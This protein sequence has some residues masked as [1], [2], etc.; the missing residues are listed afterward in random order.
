MSYMNYSRDFNFAGRNPNEQQITPGL[1]GSSTPMTGLSEDSM[2]SPCYYGRSTMVPNAGGSSMSAIDDCSSGF[3]SASVSSFPS[4]LP[5]SASTTINEYPPQPMPLQS[6]QLPPPPPDIEPSKVIEELGEYISND[7]DPVVVANSVGLLFSY[8]VTSARS[9]EICKLMSVSPII[10]NGLYNLVT[11]PEIN[12][13]TIKSLA[14]ANLTNISKYDEGRSALL[15][16]NGQSANEWPSRGVQALLHSLQSHDSN[17]V[18]FAITAIHNLLLDRRLEVQDIAKRQIQYA[19]GI[20]YIVSQL[21]HQY[22]HKYEFKVIVL[23]CLQILAYGNKDHRLSILKSDGPRLLLRTITQNFENSPTEELIETASRVLKSLSVCP[24]N[25]DSIIRNDGIEILTRCIKR[26]NQE[27]L[28][29]CLWT[30]RNLSDVINNNL[31]DHSS[32]VNLLVERLLCILFEYSE[33]PCI[34][35][36]ALG[37]LANLTCNNDHIKEF[38]CE[39]RQLNWTGVDLLLNTIDVALR[40]GRDFRV[41][42]AEVL[43]P[44]IY[45]LCHLM[46]QPHYPKLPIER[47]RVKERF[48]MDPAFRTL[49]QWSSSSEELT[50]AVGKLHSLLI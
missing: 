8:A 40:D 6:V 39:Y 30:L 38:I 16:C 49:K 3:Q 47:Q 45:T 37:I 21:A 11:N 5:S 14:T 13:D 35:T 22:L 26:D 2:P 32:A 31:R 41:L 24:A 1:I 12:D 17:V 7:R 44:G 27:T 43:E 23:D 25:K 18:I 20:K 15:G 33:E 9:A 28:K 48:T 34:V 36:C 46:N 10:L 4:T 19:D 50:K 42:N 29:T